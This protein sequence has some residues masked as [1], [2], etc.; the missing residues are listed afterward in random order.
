MASI[1][2][3]PTSLFLAN[4]YS[5]D[6]WLT[7][8]TMLGFAVF[9]KVIHNNTP[10]SNLE[11]IVLVLTPFLAVGPKAI[12]CLTILLPLLV[13]ARLL[14]SKKDVIL[15]RVL[16]IS[17]FTF[18]LFSFL[19]PFYLHGPGS[20][21][22]RGGAEVNSTDQ[23]AYILANPLAYSWTLARYVT[24][25]L[26]PLN[27]AEVSVSFVYLG[28][29][30]YHIFILLLIVI[31]LVGDWL[32][33]SNIR[34]QLII[35][36][37]ILILAGVLITVALISTALY[38]SFTAVQAKNIA[39]VQGRYL[40]PLL[41]FALISIIPSVRFSYA[42]NPIQ[43]KISQIGIIFPAAI[44]IICCY[45]IWTNIGIRYF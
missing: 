25:Y 26:S 28:L 39:G 6:P 19:I 35:R 21:D 45:G 43:D 15:Y 40:I 10:A 31:C 33:V 11:K 27:F 13:P 42:T 8:L 17:A 4:H 1:G 14:G 2:L 9:L 41:S 20:G 12:Y 5:Y 22:W 18:A 23:I 36:N 38:I 34:S 29:I 30:K 32:A 3:L 37:R 7:S 44:T 24:Y 16:T